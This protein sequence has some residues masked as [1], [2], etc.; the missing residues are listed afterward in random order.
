MILDSRPTL[1]RAEARTVYDSFAVKGHAGGRD[2]TSGYGGP[3]VQALLAMA[4]FSDA[5]SVVDYGCGQGKLAE[6]VLSSHPELWWRGVDQ[7]PMMV[8]KATARLAR[9]GPRCSVELLAGGDPAA[10]AVPGDGEA[11]RFVSTYCLDLMSE[12]D[13]LATLDKAAACLHPERGLLL[14]AGI[15][16][17]YRMSLRTFFMTLVWELLYRFRR[18]VVGGCRPQHL[19]P[20]LRAKGWRIVKEVHTHAG[21]QPATLASHTAAATVCTYASFWLQPRVQ[22]RTAPA[23]F[24]WMAS[25]VLAARPPLASGRA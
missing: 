12:M 20:Y 9:F 7:S 6:L 5:R 22:V 25:E 2:V 19:A 24:P 17:G 15:T 3:A 18:K 8:E 21:P 23:G 4:A 16:W 1:T 14:L 10:L 13:M 11:D